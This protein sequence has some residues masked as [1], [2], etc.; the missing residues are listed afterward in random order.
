MNER[1]RLRVIDREFSGDLIEKPSGYRKLPDGNEIETLFLAIRLDGPGVFPDGNHTN[2]E[3]FYKGNWVPG[4]VD[5][6]P[7]SPSH[8]V[9][10]V[11]IQK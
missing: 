2:I 11:T 8:S 3:V 10:F 5:R 1:I 9:I 7:S 6:P 4:T